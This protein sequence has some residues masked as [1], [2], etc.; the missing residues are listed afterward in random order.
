MITYGIYGYEITKT[1]ELKGFKLIPRS[2]N[3][4]E[5]KKLVVF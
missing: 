1:A 3:H 2:Q 4:R 5:V